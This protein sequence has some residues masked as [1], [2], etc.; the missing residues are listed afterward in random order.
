MR[1]GALA[2]FLVAVLALLTAC[3]GSDRP[4][5]V[6]G[7]R[8]EVT[9]PDLAAIKAK[10][11]I[12]NCPKV[13]GGQADGGMPAVTLECLGGGRSVDLAGLRGPM[14][15]NFWQAYC[16]PCRQEMPSLAAYARS[17]PSVK[18]LGVDYLDVQPA[19]ALKLARDSKV[20]YPL[21]A[22]PEGHLAGRR[23][24][25]RIPGLPFTAYLDASG[26][27]VHVEA[28]PMTTEQDVA[29]AAQKYLGTGG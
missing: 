28:V 4:S 14:I 21:V 8:L 23:P 7:T 22:D 26:R 3:A 25:T 27:V 16:G 2:A 12:P 18:V 19:A 15:V 29:T 20:A 17:H 24:L 11:D 10:S 5:I 9:S 13:S 1:R 6:G